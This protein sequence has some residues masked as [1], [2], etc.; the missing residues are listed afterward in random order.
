[1]SSSDAIM[2]SIREN[3]IRRMARAEEDERR[4]MTAFRAGRFE[5]YWLARGKEAEDRVEV[6]NE[7]IKKETADSSSGD[8]GTF[9]GSESSSNISND[10][11]DKSSKSSEEELSPPTGA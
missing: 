5:E 8:T 10:D 6:E 11:R 3:S 4:S 9:G 7:R 2:N 1:M